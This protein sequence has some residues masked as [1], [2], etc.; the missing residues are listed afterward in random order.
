MEQKR[1]F[2]TPPLSLLPASLAATM[3]L[4]QLLLLLA[5]VFAAS[6]QTQQ[7]SYSGSTDCA[8][9]LGDP[10][11]AYFRSCGFCTSAAN[12]G[13]CNGEPATQTPSSCPVSPT[14]AEAAR[15]LSS[16]YWLVCLGVLAAGVTAVL[17]YAP[18]EH[19]CGQK[20]VASSHPGFG[21]ARHVLFMSCCCLWLGLSLGLAA[22]ALP[23]LVAAQ[24]RETEAASAFSVFD[25]Q[26]QGDSSTVCIQIPLTSYLNMGASSYLHPSAADLAYVQNALALGSIAYIIN[27]GLL[28]PC[29]LMTSVALYRLKALAKYGTPAYTSG[30]SA[31]SLSVAQMLGWPAFAVFAIAFFCALSLVASAADKLT[32]SQFLSGGA[33][34]EY[35]LMPGSVAA[36]LSFALQLAGLA[37]QAYAARALSSVSGVGCNSGGCCTLRL[38]LDDGRGAVFS[39]SSATLLASA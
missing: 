33:T 30:C 35:A 5:L 31:G 24:I 12:A 17:A 22:P 3:A 19:L 8:T 34:V 4:H 9:C 14:A 2:F 26:L 27:A 36:G 7:C 25:C 37:L 15:P 16:P 23:W 29:A 18:L 13:T 21:V 20:V 10:N 6:G 32:S 11:C 28:L 38:A 1:F 39:D